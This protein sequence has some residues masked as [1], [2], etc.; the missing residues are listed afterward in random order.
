LTHHSDN[1]GVT[2]LVAAILGFGTTDMVHGLKSLSEKWWIIFTYI[3]H[4]STVSKVRYHANQY[5]LKH[6]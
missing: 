2:C 3:T 1:E 4:K 5:A 6:E